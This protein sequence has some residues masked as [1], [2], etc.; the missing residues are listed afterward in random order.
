M[1]ICI[2][3]AIFE[4]LPIPPMNGLRTFFGSRF[5]YIF[6]YASIIACGLLLSY[7]SGPLALIGSIVA[8]ALMLMM[9]FVYVDKRW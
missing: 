7:V 9:F 6:V 5:V 8:G 2:L 4:M 3:I 1:T